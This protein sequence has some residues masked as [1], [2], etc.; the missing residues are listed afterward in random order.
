MLQ[1]GDMLI[2]FLMTV[3]K[4]ELD[5]A[6]MLVVPDLSDMFVPLSEGFLVDPQESR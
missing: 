4:A 1:C 6:Q 2:D 5:N 3:F